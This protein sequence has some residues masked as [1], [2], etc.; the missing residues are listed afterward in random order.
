MVPA[1][2]AAVRLSPFRLSPGC[3]RSG[4]TT[5]RIAR[6]RFRGDS[7]PRRA[8][9]PATWRSLPAPGHVLLRRRLIAATR[10]PRLGRSGVAGCSYPVVLP[11]AR[12]QLRVPGPRARRGSWPG[13]R[14]VRRRSPARGRCRC[15]G[16][17]AR[18][19][20]R[21]EADRLLR[22]GDPPGFPVRGGAGPPRV[23]LPQDRGGIQTRR[24]PEMAGQ[25][26][27]GV[28]EGP[29]AEFLAPVIEPGGQLVSQRRSVRR[30]PLRPRRTVSLRRELQAL[31]A[32][33]QDAGDGPGAV[34]RGRR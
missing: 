19:R 14:L 8:Q 32:A 4:Q 31:Q 26:R 27:L 9:W 3:W 5:P 21:A 11:R 28:G 1:H 2:G 34:H 25:P 24:H 6:S 15:A 10:R 13:S 7:S 20:M 29:F 22:V 23:I 16:L 30:C 18:V 17:R 12:G 33:V